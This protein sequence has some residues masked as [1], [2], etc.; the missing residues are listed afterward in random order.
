VHKLTGALAV[1]L[2]VLGCSQPQEIPVP[3]PTPKQPTLDQ[4]KS[5]AD[6]LLTQMA[7]EDYKTRE[8]A[9]NN[10]HHLLQKYAQYSHVLFMHLKQRLPQSTDPELKH[11]LETIVGHYFTPWEYY[12]ILHTLGDGSDSVILA[13][14]EETD[15]TFKDSSVPSATFSPDGSLLASGHV[16]GKVRVWD[17]STGKCL[18]QLL[19]HKYRVCSVRFSPDGKLLASSGRDSTTRVWDTRTW[20]C[21]QVLKGQKDGVFVV[22]F[23]PDA[24]LLASGAGDSNVKIWNVKTGECINTLDKHFSQVYALAFS[25]DGKFLASSGLD[26]AIIIWDIKTGKSLRV[27]PD[28]EQEITSLAY[29]PDGKILAATGVGTEIRIWDPHSGE[30][31]RTLDKHRNS[32]NFVT[33]SK[34][35]RFIASC[36]WEE[37]LIWNAETEKCVG[38]L[39]ADVQEIFEVSFSPQCKS[40]AASTKKGSIIIWGIPE[41]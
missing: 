18:Q 12:R 30:L 23:S 2:L 7:S 1:A 15:I 29:S 31:L 35:G 32:P 41:E 6:Q 36:A 28:R 26:R 9:T 8:K 40:L 13:F 10:L 4:L 37:V 5:R 21:L 14:D 20:K 11:R 39:K 22:C 34:D 38:R 19:G 17:S 33:F 16:N 24:T 3:E 27:L 25:P